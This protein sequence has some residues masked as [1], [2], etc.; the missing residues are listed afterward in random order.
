MP[1]AQSFI[2]YELMTPDTDAAKAFYRT[3][4]GWKMQTFGGGTDYT[5]LDA[6]DGQVG[7]IMA[8][9]AEA[10]KG[11][12]KPCWMGYIGVDDVDAVAARIAR[13]GGAIHK[14]PADIPD[15]GRFA[16]VADPQGAAFMLLKGATHAAPPEAFKAK[17]ARHV[18]WNELHTTDWKQGFDFYAQL[19]G[20]QKSDALDMG[21]MGTY[22]VFNAGGDPVGGMMTSPNFPRPAWLFYFNVD[23][24]D[25]AHARLTGAGG[26]VLLPPSEVPGGGWI[27]QATDPQGAM[28]AVVGPRTA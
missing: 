9:P 16:V 11:G 8:L 6:G 15:V 5:V 19:F 2:W 13:A 23:D 10:A 4:V 1:T 14:A 21:A 17:T 18:G 12:L 3:V 26:Q 27:V 28:F 22:L 7:G 25:A 24:I 20:W